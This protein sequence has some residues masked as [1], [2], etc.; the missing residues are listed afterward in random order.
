MPAG[1]AGL[2]QALD[3]IGPIGAAAE[4]A[5]DHQA[6]ARRTSPCRGRPRNCGR[7][8]GSA[9]GAGSAPSDPAARRRCCAAASNASSVSAL[10][11][12]TISP[13]VWARS[14]AADAVGDR[15]RQG[16]EQVHSARQRRGDGGAVEA[17]LADHDEPRLGARSPVSPRPV[18]ILLHPVADRLD[19]L[20]PVAAGQ[21]DKA[22]DPQHVV[23]GGWQRR[24]RARNASPSAT[25]PSVTTKLSKSS[26]SCAISRSCTDGRAARSSSAAAARPSATSGATAAVAGGDQL[27]PG[28][29]P[30]ARS[31]GAARPGV[32]R[33]PGRSCSGSTRSAQAS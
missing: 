19:D 8:A 18:E 15:A 31:R 11:S 6:R 33:R 7:A 4:H 10:D 21:V 29:Q 9:P 20:P 23:R 16:R 12:T 30:L 5:G 25:G 13:G 2:D 22:L 3:A 32:R 28:P 14:T 26:W 17:L 27:H 1:A 24:R